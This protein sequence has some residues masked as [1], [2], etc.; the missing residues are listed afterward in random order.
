MFVGVGRP[1]PPKAGFKPPVTADELINRTI[2]GYFTVD[3]DHTHRAKKQ[4]HRK[5]AKIPKWANFTVTVYVKSPIL[6]DTVQRLQKLSSFIFTKV[7]II[8]TTKKPQ[9]QHQQ[10]QQ[11]QHQQQRQQQIKQTT[12]TTK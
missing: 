9:P 11:Q 3:S 2:E 6:F 10:Q 1:L 8:S 7:V 12:I 4:L 5:F